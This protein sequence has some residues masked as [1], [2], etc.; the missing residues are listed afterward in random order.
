MRRSLRWKCV[1]AAV[2]I[3]MTAA[4]CARTPAYVYAPTAAPVGGPYVPPPA[5]QPAPVMAVP[6]DP[7]LP[8]QPAGLPIEPY[9]LD[10][11]DRLRVQV[12]GQDGLSNTYIVDAAGNVSLALVGPVAARGLTTAQ[13]ARAITTR[14]QQG[15]LREPRV[16]VEVEAYRPFFILG[17]VNAPGQYPYVAN[18]TAESAVAIAGGYAPR[19]DKKK[20]TITRNING[21]M[22]RQNVPLNYPV[23]PGDTITISERWL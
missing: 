1:T 17:E 22:L 4:G 19:A 12:F 10:S 18:M 16:S 7:Y 8:A 15:Y 23:R 2:L 3:A 6:A 13:L 20:I 5:A 9:L 11:G 14:L 21:Q